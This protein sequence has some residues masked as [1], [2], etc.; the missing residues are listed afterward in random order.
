[1]GQHISSIFTPHI[2]PN[3][4]QKETW[5]LDWFSVLNL[6]R[7]DNELITISRRLQCTSREPFGSN[8]GC[9]SHETN[10]IYEVQHVDL[11]KI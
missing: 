4:S 8:N 6:R 9:V 2:S 1:M 10:H 11:Q 7:I 3:N 5:S